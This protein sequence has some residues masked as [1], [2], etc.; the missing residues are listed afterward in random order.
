MIDGV[1]GG[2]SSEHLLLAEFA[3]GNEDFVVHS[4]CVVDQGLNTCLDSSDV[5]LVKAGAVVRAC[6]VLYLGVVDDECV[7]VRGVLGFR[8][9]GMVKLDSEI[10]DVIASRGDRYVQRILNLG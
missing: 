1:V 7:L 2:L 8:G 5:V 9:E 3:R 4:A 6:G 10:S